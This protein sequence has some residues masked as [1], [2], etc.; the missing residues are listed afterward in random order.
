M[1]RLATGHLAQTRPHTWRTCQGEQRQANSDSWCICSVMGLDQQVCTRR[2]FGFD[3]LGLGRNPDLLQ[4]FQE[5][6]LVHSRWAMLGG[7]LRPEHTAVCSGHECAPLRLLHCAG[8]AGCLSVELVGQGNWF[9]AP[10]WVRWLLWAQ[11][12]D[13]STTAFHSGKHWQVLTGGKPTYLGVEVP[14]DF[15]T[16]LAVVRSA[17]RAKSSRQ[18]AACSQD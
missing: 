2:S 18:S 4:R 3:P 11:S 6:E 5:S 16:I 14:L 7:C 15:N 10:N 13:A 17:C 1:L 9:D 8:V 12:T